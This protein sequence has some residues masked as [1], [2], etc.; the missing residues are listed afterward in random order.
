MTSV[1]LSDDDQVDAGDNIGCTPPKRRSLSSR[2]EHHVTFRNHCRSTRRRRH[3]RGNGVKFYGTRRIRNLWSL[4]KATITR[5][6]F[7]TPRASPWNCQRRV[8]QS[9]VIVISD[10]EDC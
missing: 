7:L 1:H 10:D 8:R 3:R 2:K 5:H 9:S 4:K 6:H